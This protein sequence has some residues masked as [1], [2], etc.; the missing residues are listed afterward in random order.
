MVASGHGRLYAGPIT[1]AS[2]LAYALATIVLLDAFH[3]TW[4]YW[5]HRAL[6]SRLLYKRIHYMHHRSTAPTA[7]AGYSFHVIEAI[8]VFVNGIIECFLFPIHAGLH[9][10]YHLWTIAIH[11]GGHAGY[12]IAP[13]IPNV[14]QLAW[15]LAG[16][17]RH[18]CTA[19]ATVAHHDLH[20]RYP[21]R[22]FAL[23]FTHSD[24]WC[25]TEDSN[26]RAKA[27]RTKRVPAVKEGIEVPDVN[28]RQQSGTKTEGIFIGA[29]WPVLQRHPITLKK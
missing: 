16:R 14:Q 17:W 2:G 5:A 9:R 18:Q 24:A 6:H 28:T 10:A 1:T 19:L 29:H 27:A 20:H 7:F 8:L 25:G 3:D 15:C 21:N 23:Y 4:F 12:E 22:H 11:I 13:F 26:Y